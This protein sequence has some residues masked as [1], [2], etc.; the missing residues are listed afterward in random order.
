MPIEIIGLTF[1]TAAHAGEDKHEGFQAV[2]IPVLWSHVVQKTFTLKCFCCSYC[3]SSLP[4]FSSC[5]LCFLCLLCLKLPTI[6]SFTIP[7][8][9][10]L[11]VH[12]K[13]E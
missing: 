12:F 4:V 11:I 1:T 10:P 8:I 9:S 7:F 2:T 6:A 3:F 13:S 5:F